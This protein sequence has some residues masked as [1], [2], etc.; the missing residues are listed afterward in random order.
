MARVTLSCT[1]NYTAHCLNFWR[2]SY[3]AQAAFSWFLSPFKEDVS[4]FSNYLY[5]SSPLQPQ[6]AEGE[7]FLN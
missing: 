1:P 7:M 5:C 6:L 4:M 3:E 2:P